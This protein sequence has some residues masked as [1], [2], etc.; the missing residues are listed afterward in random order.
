MEGGQTRGDRTSM[1]FHVPESGSRQGKQSPQKNARLGMWGPS[2]IVPPA[3]PLLTATQRQPALVQVKLIH[4]PLHISNPELLPR[5]A[6]D[7]PF[8]N[9]FAF[10]AFH[11][12]QLEKAFQLCGGATLWCK[13]GL[14]RSMLISPPPP[15]PLPPH[16]VACCR[17][18]EPNPDD[19]RF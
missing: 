16:C 12:T 6:L 19:P 13:L 8:A 4:I 1:R 9:E 2:Q 17:Q 11:C 5:S 14:P 7:T 3:R 18:L 10:T 15:S